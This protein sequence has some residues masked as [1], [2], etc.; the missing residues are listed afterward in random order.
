MNR[1][2][3]SRKIRH[4]TKKK[5]MAPEFL[6]LSQKREKSQ[7]VLHT[8][9][10]AEKQGRESKM[11][12]PSKKDPHVYC[13]KLGK[14]SILPFFF[15]R[16]GGGGGG[17]GG[18]GKKKKKKTVAQVSVSYQMHHHRRRKREMDLVAAYDERVGMLRGK[19]KK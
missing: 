11:P 3:L 16:R 1:L 6:H 17:E 2:A 5:R 12:S 13:G 10:A 8:G 18:G 4:S 14:G 19:K 9:C 7:T 15:S